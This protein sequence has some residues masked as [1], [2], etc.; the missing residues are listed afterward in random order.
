M[1]ALLFRWTRWLWLLHRGR[2]ASANIGASAWISPLQVRNAG[3]SHLT[4]G[5]GAIVHATLCFDRAGSRISIGRNTYVGRS[6]I[7]AADCVTVGD[8]VLISWDVTIIDHN[9]HSLDARQREKDCADW[10]TGTKDWTD[11][12]TAP[13]VISDHAWLGFGATI[14]KGVTVG[15]G[16]IIAAQ[17]VVTKDVAP[18]TIV[19]GNPAVVIGS[20]PGG[21]SA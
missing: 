19:G 10:R 4:V 11:I 15:E 8:H 2:Y 13:V 5:E 20:A 7:V 1:R 6:Q 14:L 12:A 16:A 17:S 3:A 18:Y 21:P 9:S